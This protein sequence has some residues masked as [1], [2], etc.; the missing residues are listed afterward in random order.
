MCCASP[1]SRHTGFCEEDD[2]LIRPLPR[3]RTFFRTLA[4]AAALLLPVT[5]VMAQP[6]AAQ[7]AAASALRAETPSTEVHGLKGEYFSMSAPGARDFA[8]LGATVLDPEINFP[9]L[10]G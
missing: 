8:E 1:V 7:P 3:P 6:A 2:A 9:N 5:A 10:T 4:C